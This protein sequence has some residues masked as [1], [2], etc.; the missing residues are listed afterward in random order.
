MLRLG[1]KLIGEVKP[2]E[3]QR[4]CGILLLTMKAKANVV[5]SYK[6]RRFR[7]YRKLKAS[8]VG[9]SES[10]TSKRPEG[11]DALRNSPTVV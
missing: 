1:E 4:G 5:P 11:G 10:L 2:G 9:A 8:R 7:D 6:S 3:P